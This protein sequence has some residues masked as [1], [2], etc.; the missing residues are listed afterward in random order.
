M[1][2]GRRAHRRDAAEALARFS[3]PRDLVRFAVTSFANAGIDY[4]HGTD[5]AL[6]EA[7]WLVCA[8]LSLPIEHH[9]TFADARLT[10]REVAAVLRLIRL[11]CDSR[12]PL[13]YLIGEAWL[14]GF[15]F[16][17]D[18]RALVPRSPIVEA[19][20]AGSLSPWF[21]DRREPSSILDLCTG[22]GSIAIVAASLHRAASVVASDLSL[23]ALALAAQN[24]S[25]H[26]LGDRIRLVHGDL[27]DALGEARFDLILCN[28]PYVNETSMQQLP[29]EYLAEPR[30]ALAGGDDGMA[31][32]AR[33][34]RDAPAHLA[35]EGLL[36][37]EMGHEA[38][39]FERR[40]P[41]LEHAWIEV[42]AG[43]RQIAAITA[44]AL[45]AAGATIRG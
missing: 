16:V 10:R 38:D 15:R 24:V 36:V 22:G 25:L 40:F 32:I 9:S 45:R 41:A 13:A 21:D 1:N 33:I 26:A 12:Q 37:L 18:A 7:T 42:A 17:C 27:F 3:T 29:P 30:A 23:D 6:D 20:L 31:L 19:M 11:R 14:G 28:P 43:E 8:A 35:A 39:A 4:G 5:N 44:G 34:L 2:R